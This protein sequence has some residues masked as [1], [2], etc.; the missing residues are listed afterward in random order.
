[1]LVANACSGTAL[2]A[3]LVI[4]SL[5]Q[6][7]DEPIETGWITL[8][9]VAHVAA[10]TAVW[11]WHSQRWALA[12]ISL[13]LSLGMPWGYFVE[14]A[15]PVVAGLATTAGVRAFRRRRE[16]KPADPNKRL[17]I[18]E[19]GAGWVGIA[20][21]A[22]LTI[23]RASNGD[24]FDR[25]VLPTLAFGGLFAVPGFLALLARWDRPGLYLASG[26]IYFPASFVSFSG[27][28][29]PLLFLAAMA[30]IAYGRHGDESLTKV[31]APLTALV[32]FVLNIATW[33][34]LIF[35]GGDD[36][37]CSSTTTSTSWSMS[38]TSDVITNGE[39]LLGL[40]GVALTLVAAWFLSSPLASNYTGPRGV[41]KRQ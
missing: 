24:D 8:F 31:A 30:F 13:V 37:R 19:F 34:A 4:D 28:T 3:Y 33:A 26:L 6:Y 27:V 5:G 15:F 10:W 17:G 25:A 11:A 23:L 22:G 2:T 18:A 1:M 38:C 32:L 7:R 12:A 36:P 39:A 21:G 41:R 35:N 9:V 40:A 16:R 29:L 20:A 14:I